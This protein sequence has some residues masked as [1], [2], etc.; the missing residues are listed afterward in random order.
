MLTSRQR[1]SK[2][3]RERNPK[4]NR[5]L[6]AE[7]RVNNREKTRRAVRN[8][9]LKKKYGITIEQFNEI[10]ERQ[11]GVC[12]ICKRECEY[13]NLSVDHDHETG[14]VRALLCRKCNLAVGFVGEDIEIADRLRLYLAQTMFGLDPIL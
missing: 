4:E 8:S 9:H 11:G 10:L 14:K 5:R 7:Y 12:L 1:A 3:W 2:A 6:Q 13:G